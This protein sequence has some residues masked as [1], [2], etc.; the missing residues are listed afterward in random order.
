MAAI[1]QL[2]RA[3]L[4][5]G[6]LAAEVEDAVVEAE[7]AVDRVGAR[8]D[9]LHDR[10][11]LVDVSSATSSAPTARNSAQTTATS[12]T[13]E[14]IRERTALA[15]ATTLL[16][17]L[18][19]LASCARHRCVVSSVCLDGLLGVGHAVSWDELTAP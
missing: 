19:V 1:P 5:L 10:V 8:Q 3:S 9:E 14:A 16:A 15:P 12:Q 13:T 11:V 18:P 17:D 2:T 7:R 6:A 4:V